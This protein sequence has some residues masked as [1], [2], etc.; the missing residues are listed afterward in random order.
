VAVVVRNDRENTMATDNWTDGS[1]NWDTPSDWSAG[2][3]G[4][5][6]NVVIDQGDPQVTASFGTI[7][8]LNDAAD[9]TFI[10]AGKSTVTGAVT[11]S[12][13]IDL[14][15][16]T[17]DG[18]SSLSIGGALDN[19]GTL[20]IGPS[21]N[22]LSANS[23]VDV[24][25]LANF[26]GT[27]F[28]T[29]DLYG[30]STAEATL[31]DAAA[32]GLGAANTLIGSVNLSGDALLEF[33][34]GQI[35][36]IDSNS[37]L[38]L[39]GANAFVADASK[40]GSESALTGLAT[41][42]GGLYLV[43][44]ATVTTS[45]G[46][47][48]SGSIYLD[49][50]TDDGGSSLTVGGGLTNDG[51][52]A[53]GPTNDTLSAAT[54][55]SATGITNFIGT[56]FGTIDVYGNDT[57]SL[58][59]P[60][61]AALDISGA[62]G[63]GVANTVEGNVNVEYDGKIVFAS[64][65]ITTIAAHSEL[66]L[67]DKDAVVADKSNTTSNSALTGLTTVDGDLLLE[68]GATVT[69][70]A[71]L[72][73]SGSIYL[74][75]YTDD[76]GSSLTVG[77][78]LTNTGTLAIGPS[79]DTLTSATTVSAT[80]ITN[81]V[82]TTFG[83][84]D[85][86]G[87]DSASLP[88]PIPAALDISGAAGFGVAGKVEGNVNVEYDGQ[89]V[90]AS[91]QITAIAA[92]SE[93]SLVDK[94]A[95]VA[96]ASNTSSNSAL[97]GLT[98]VT[99]GLYLYNGATVT[100]SAGLTN[101][102]SI[103]LD[104]YTDDGG[105]SLTVGGRITN[106]GTLAI[107]PSNDTLTSA[108]TVSATGITNFVSTTFGT[109][110]VYGNDSSDLPAPIPAALDISGAAGFGAANTLEG[111]VNVSFDGQIVFGSGEIKTIAANSEL[112]LTDKDAV[113]ADKSNTSS[114]SALTGLATVTGDLY[115]YNGATV[116]TTG[117][118][119]N[120]GAIILDQF[121]DNG[122]SS[123]TVGAGLTNTGTI[124]IGPS[125]DTLSAADKVKAASVDNSG[126]IDVYGN[127][128][129]LIDASLTSTGSFTNN[130][131]VNFSDD[132]DTIAGTVSGTGNFGLSNGSTV[133]FSAGVSS[134]ETV[135]YGGGAADLLNLKAG[136]SFDATIE[137]FFTVGDAVDLTNFGH[138]ASTFLY[139]QTGADSASWTVTDGSKKA[140][141]N[142]AGEPYTKSDFSIVSANGGGS[143]IKFVG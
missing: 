123:L 22:T 129:N 15:P 31:D 133:T 143:E 92:H 26:I 12:G 130:G 132:V 33:A 37:E 116:T 126:T 89:I 6:S 2:L 34:S 1:D 9:L 102:G 74:D 50:Y 140:V 86:Y 30:S 138:S 25:S 47:T 79:N 28:G 142:L 44:G 40:T 137:D 5:S 39:T 139:T 48:N 8:S 60:I 98:T 131:M 134:G 49:L 51:T 91:G 32:A 104:Q 128:A 135:T 21:N 54:T 93:L 101:S 55:V 64:G 125:N 46:L 141:I 41:N 82:S 122:G 67:V 63:F 136:Q 100:T 94:D 71:G 124:A 87:N 70:S 106:T 13:T 66:T 62:A 97:T 3:P 99:G 90:F 24:A 81:F 115:L 68:N 18:G 84:I 58:P 35:T 110:D 56:N 7:A 96:D 117:A 103:V 20:S 85:V 78:K 27:T 29:I 11:N 120:S 112:S 16:F 69:T 17:D 36:T 127:A 119:S 73:N 107:G 113:V 105:S 108:T 114:N 80:S 76:G 77:G 42:N 43:N 72:T 121:T 38:S 59:A 10:D 14:D 111:D 83:T 52:I 88:A 65:Q 57:A 4:S 19:S 95:V 53:I 109:I 45:A 118:L 23:T 75:L 61:P